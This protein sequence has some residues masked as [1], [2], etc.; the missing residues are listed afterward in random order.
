MKI[1]PF[2]PINIFQPS[3]GCSCPDE[4]CQPIRWD[5]PITA[6]FWR[7]GVEFVRGE[8]IDRNGDKWE[9]IPL[10][11]FDFRDDVFR[12]SVRLSDFLYPAE[13]LCPFK[14]RFFEDVG[15]TEIQLPDTNCFNIVPDTGCEVLL[16]AGNAAN[17]FGFDFE[18]NWLFAMRL[19]LTLRRV[20]YQEQREHFRDSKGVH[21]LQY[22]RFNKRYEMMIGSVPEWVHDALRMM[23]G[24]TDLRINGIQ[25]MKDSGEYVPEFNNTLS[26]WQGRMSVVEDTR[27]R[28]QRCANQP[29][30]RIPDTELPEIQST[31]P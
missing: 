30:E 11:W 26:E 7:E 2:Q 1:P 13:L 21:S 10:E 25:I 3:P 17:A 27:M 20:E 15:E 18:D 9:D 16:T 6:Q 12:L 5:D 23:V 24:C 8:I 19:P 22:D 28:N 14:L 4:Y 29:I 31:V